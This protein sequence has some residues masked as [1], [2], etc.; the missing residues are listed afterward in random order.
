MSAP[1]WF[2]WKKSTSRPEL[3]RPRGDLG[4]DLVERVV[5]VDL[6]LARPD[7]VEVRAL[8]DQDAGHGR[9]A[10]PAPTGASRPAATRST[11]SAGTSAR[12]S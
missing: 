10:R 8:E 4:V 12:T 11:S 7:E 5:A 2:D 1:S 3:R 9:P 6:G